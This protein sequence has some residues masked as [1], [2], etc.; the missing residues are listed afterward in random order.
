MIK[1]DL[2]KLAEEFE[3]KQEQGVA[4]G[5]VKG[6]AVT[7]TSGAGNQRLMIA[8]R[9]ASNT[10]KDALM[11]IIDQQDLKGQYN[12]RKLQIAKKVIFVS[13]SDRP[14]NEE[15]IRSFID[16]F[17]PLLEQF[18]ASAA[19]ICV[20][21]Q[22]AIEEEEACWILRDGATAFR[23]HKACAEELKKTVEDQNQGYQAKSNGSLGKGILGLL[24][25][26]L[27]G[28]A[29]WILMQL[30]HFYAPIAGLANGWLVVFF[31][32]KM[33]GSNHKL[34]I[35]LMVI[36]GI[37]SIC[38]SV[39]C[40]ELTALLQ[41]GYALQSFSLFFQALSTNVDFQ[42]GI[43]GNVM[44]GSLFM[45]LGIFMSLKSIARNT[46]TLVVTD[47]GE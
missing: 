24:I 1:G 23:M 26:I 14:D 29:L 33:K 45:C 39:V 20:Q 10:D 43:F 35:P 22:E 16:W 15:K 32:G 37:L 4:Y 9:F 34:R 18:G 17:F 8:T 6:Y 19:D 28:A 47:L 5:I 7:F 38:L 13:F 30:V 3:L 40:C 46:T 11:H 25:G 12:V 27:L 44:M 2:L 21:C 31:Y 36:S 41:K 42:G